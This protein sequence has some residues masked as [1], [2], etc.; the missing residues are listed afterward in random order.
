M[1]I[2]T[3]WKVSRKE[4][5]EVSGLQGTTYLE[6]CKDL[7]HKNGLD[8]ALVHKFLIEDKGT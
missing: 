4:L 2:R 1:A 5:S 3:C 7:G 6:K 8:M